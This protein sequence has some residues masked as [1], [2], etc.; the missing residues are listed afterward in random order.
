MLSIPH[1][2]VI[3]VVVLVVFGPQKLP[4]LARGLGK[5]MAE[6]RKAS[7]DFKTA[8]E[9][10]MRDLERQALLAERRKAAEAAAASATTQPAQPETRSAPVSTPDSSAEPQANDAPVIAPVGESVARGSEAAAENNAESA[11][12]NLPE[13]SQDSQHPA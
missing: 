6:F 5:L 1:M 3:F 4:E 7:L 8:F 13:S 2:I 11:T 10:E 9:E 12:A